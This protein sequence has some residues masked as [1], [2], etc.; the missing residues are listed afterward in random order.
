MNVLNEEKED[1]L[2]AF[3]TLSFCADCGAGAESIMQQSIYIP[4][5][6]CPINRPKSVSY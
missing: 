6:A 3:T 1:P 2:R 4:F 5:H